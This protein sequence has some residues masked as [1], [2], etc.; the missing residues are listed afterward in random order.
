M[1]ELPQEEHRIEYPRT[2]AQP[3]RSRSPTNQRWRRSGKS[4]HESAER[5]LSF[6][7]RIEH[8]VA[9]QRGNGEQASKQIDAEGKVKRPA[10]GKQHSKTE[11][12]MWF[13]FARCQR[14]ASG[15][16]HLSIEV[17]L[18]ILVESA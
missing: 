12:M 13:Y 5:R 4:A 11:C 7:R 16:A 17:S 1:R 10:T 18:D 15:A 6:E 9:N 14:S 8:Q 2:G 3:S